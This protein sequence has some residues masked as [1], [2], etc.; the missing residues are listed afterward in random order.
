MSLINKMLQD[1]DARG[2]QA[3]ATALPH[4][5][6]VP[7]REPRLPVRT[8]AIGAALLLTMMLAALAW[9]FMPRPAAAPH[10]PGPLASASA[11]AVPVPIAPAPVPAAPIEPAPEAPPSD[12][13]APPAL[14]LP[15]TK[16][17]P[18]KV[19]VANKPPKPEKIAE[20]A[21]ADALASA[22]PAQSELAAPAASKGREMTSQQR[23]EGE[24]RTSMT[25][26]QEGRVRLA[27]AGLE[28]ALQ[29][30]PRHEA[31]RQTLIGLL[32]ESKRN[33]EA[34][35]QLQLGLGLDPRQPA[36]AMVLARLQVEVGG[37]AIETLMRTLPFASSANGEY[38]A[39]LAALLQRDQ[40]HVEAAEHF[41][42]ALSSAP[43]NGVW[44]MGQGIS[45]QAL[46]RQTE[47]QEAFRRAK[48]SSNLT[49]ELRIFVERKLQQLEK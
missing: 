2:S 18:V 37:P 48:T 16:P 6:P 12:M 23:A 17:A 44:W 45:L 15:E 3:G 10:Q 4:V 27:I 28:Q 43:Q 33:D 25:A 38:Q 32:L 8:L 29:I 24:Y 11:A 49:P 41:Q 9:R 36:L 14:V 39:F 1:L 34:M 13:G 19:V 47:A 30:D 7:E 5:R 31:A 20:R 21:R 22:V 46:T 42:L 26:M 35:R 40:R